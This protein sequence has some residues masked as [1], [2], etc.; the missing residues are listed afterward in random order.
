MR[1][2]AVLII[3]ANISTGCSAQ[4]K[5]GQVKC[6]KPR[7]IRTIPHDPQAFTQG[8]VYKEGV[9]YESTGLYYK[10]SLRTIDAK[11]GEIINMVPV[12]DVFAEGL[13]FIKDFFVLLTWRKGRARIYS[14]PDLRQTGGFDYS[15]EGWGLASNSDSYIMSNG[16]DTIYF[17]DSS[18]NIIR[19]L[20]VRFNHKP[21]SNL[22]EL[23]FARGYIYANVWYSDSIYEIE[24]VKGKVT[25]VIDCTELKTLAKAGK[26]SSARLRKDQDVLNGIAYKSETNTFYITG[27]LWPLIFEVFIQ[28]AR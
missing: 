16:S 14:F 18:F 17:R 15:G 9:L 7:V 19:S 4:G 5:D 23:E 21:L 25:G 1:I 10:S 2:I 6:I 24:P 28:T 11:D 20:P 13:T 27:K 3:L 22:N 12:E 8:L 26:G